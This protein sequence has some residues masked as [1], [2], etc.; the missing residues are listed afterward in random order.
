MTVAQG[1]VAWMAPEV[2][3]GHTYT[4]KCDIY[5][6]AVTF[7]Q[8]LSRQLPYFNLDSPAQSTDSPQTQPD[9]A[10]AS[11]A[12]GCGGAASFRIMWAV[13]SG[14]R[15]QLLKQCP[16][17][18]EQLLENCWSEQP[19]KRPFVDQVIAQIEQLFWIIQSHSTL[20]LQLPDDPS[21]NGQYIALIIFYITW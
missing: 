20:P 9:S 10:V 21:T 4:E 16:L 13:H 7:W 15:P 19:N 14:E 11:A 3:Q 6:W 8:V 17:V 2:F 12:G 18:L 1:S 5:S